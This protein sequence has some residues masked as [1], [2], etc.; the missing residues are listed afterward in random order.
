MNQKKMKALVKTA[1]GKGLIEV[2]DVPVPRIGDDEVLIDVKAAGICGTDLH[3]YHDEFPY[4][5]PVIL[6]HE[7]AGVIAE[8]GKNVTG[9]EV[10]DRVVGE[11]HTK[12]CGTCW[13]C[14]TGNRQ[15][16]PA[17]RSPGWG[18]DGCFAKYMRYPEPA[19]LHRFPEGM[20]FQEAALVEPTANVVYDV[21]ERGGIRPVDV[22]VVIGPGPIGL[23][24]A[25][26]ARAG[27]ASRVIITGTDF[28]EEQRLPVAR[29]MSAV[30]RVINVQRENAE[31]LILDASNG[32]GAD[33]VVEASGAAA[34]IAAAFK[35]VR[36][37]GR[38]TAI[39]LTGK[40]KIEF[41]YDTGMFKAVEFIFNLSTSY[42]SWDKAI[43]LIAS[44]KIDVK[45]LI[46]HIGGLEQWQQF[47]SDLENKKGIKGMFI[48]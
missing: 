8:K 44:G 42:T 9:W 28:D 25:M 10:G 21:L 45:P 38:I 24:A 36:K 37:L 16:C 30:D 11:P 17:K 27:G 20:S 33:L 40:E 43:E 32:R 41:P 19:L 18:I 12:A 31:A 34:G 46:T 13:L 29:R 3:I 5:P 22:V 39:G 14:R 15:I 1:K 23:L 48:P 7:F 26:A 35:F 4:W 47:F 2:R 6:G